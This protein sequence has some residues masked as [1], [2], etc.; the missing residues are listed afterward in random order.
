MIEINDGATFGAIAATLYAAHKWADL[1]VQTD[2][3]AARKGRPGEE[4][5]ATAAQS[6]RALIAHVVSY[7]LVMAAMLAVVV[8]VLDL[9]VTLTG[10]SA[11]LAWSAITHGFLDR[12]WPI[13]A[14]MRRT[15]SRDFAEQPFGRFQVDQAWHVLCLWLSALLITL[16]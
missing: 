6:W 3:Q 2:A 4:N 8:L 15:G 5:P 10:A 16:L 14:W 9:P 1:A 13:R 12:R 7:H 11:G